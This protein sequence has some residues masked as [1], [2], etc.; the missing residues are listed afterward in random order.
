MTQCLCDAIDRSEVEVPYENDLLYAIPGRDSIFERFIIRFL[1][2][3]R[4]FEFIH[5]KLSIDE[6]C[7]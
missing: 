5:H 7:Q 6:S 2:K 1:E 3:R 4:Q